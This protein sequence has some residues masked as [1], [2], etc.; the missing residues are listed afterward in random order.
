MSKEDIVDYKDYKEWQKV[1]L[2]EPLSHG[3]NG[4]ALFISSFLI[5]L[6]FCTVIAF[7]ISKN[8]YSQIILILGM[9][10]GCLPSILFFIFSSNFFYK[11]KYTNK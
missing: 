3:W 6:F 9:I 11:L 1:L 10:I 2:V 5:L 4:I 7:F 8:K